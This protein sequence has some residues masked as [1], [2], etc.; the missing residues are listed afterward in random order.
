M[1]CGKTLLYAKISLRKSLFCGNKSFSVRRR[2]L[3]K[4][5]PLQEI[6]VAIASKIFL[7]R[8][9]MDEDGAMALDLLPVK[10]P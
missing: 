7:E 10:A 4:S 3:H 9:G 8:M 5:F 1:R 2:A 6:L